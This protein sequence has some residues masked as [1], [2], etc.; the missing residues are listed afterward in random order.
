MRRL[1]LS[2]RL[3]LRLRLRF[4]MGVRGLGVGL[5]PGAPGQVTGHRLGDGFTQLPRIDRYRRHRWNIGPFC[6]SCQVFDEFRHSGMMRWHEL[7]TYRGIGTGTYPHLFVPELARSVSSLSPRENLMDR[8][9][10]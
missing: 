8:S 3:S 7:R 6:K 2:L 9:A 4:S 1:R 5:L 10:H